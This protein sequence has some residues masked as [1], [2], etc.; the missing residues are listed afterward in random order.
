MKTTNNKN[1]Q[2]NITRSGKKPH[3]LLIFILILIIS[4]SASAAFWWHNTRAAAQLSIIKPSTPDNLI[5]WKV[6]DATTGSLAPEGVFL[7]DNETH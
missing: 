7:K 2:P 6:I 1:P 5:E 3:P 4:A